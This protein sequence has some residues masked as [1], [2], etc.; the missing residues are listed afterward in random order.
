MGSASL[1]G[2]FFNQSERRPHWLIGPTEKEV[3][4]RW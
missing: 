2:S 4:E 1:R 3:K